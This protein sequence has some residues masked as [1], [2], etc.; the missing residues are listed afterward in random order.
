MKTNQPKKN[1][2]SKFNLNYFILIF[3]LLLV[4]LPA[5]SS[6]DNYGINVHLWNNT[7]LAKVKEANI[8]WIRIDV[9]WADIE[10]RRGHYNFGNVDRVVHYA[11][12]NGLKILAILGDT[13][14]WANGGKSKNFPP[15][16]TKYWTNFISV[17]TKR[18]K[19]KIKYWSIWNEPNVDDFFKGSPRTYVNDILIPAVNT[20]KAIDSN[21]K[22]VAP[23]ITYLTSPGSRWDTYLTPVLNMGKK[24]IDIISMHIYDSKGAQAIMDKIE[25]GDVV[26]DSVMH[27]LNIT[28]CGG[29]D[30][31]LTE[32]G[33][34]TTNITEDQQAEHYLNILKKVLNSSSV[35]K[36]FFYEIKDI[37]DV[38]YYG[39]LKSNNTPKKAYYTYKNFIA[40]ESDYIGDDDNNNNQKKI[41]AYKYIIPFDRET[42]RKGRYIRDEIY[43]TKYNTARDNIKLYYSLSE[44]FYKIINQNPKLKKELRKLLY[45]WT[46]EVF[47][48]FDK[49]VDKDLPDNLIRRTDIFLK[50]LEK[51]SKKQELKQKIKRAITLL[52][53]YEK[54]TINRSLFD[55]IYTLNLKLLINR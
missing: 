15:L 12:N 7:V 39:I 3:I 21:S 17:T 38:S 50:T 29:K 41:C 28:G 51:V 45:L 54:T 6:S 14:S 26:Y 49:G 11:I 48:V 47:N 34:P 55:L 8:G 33:W 27:I 42:I 44:E 13:P 4:G 37:E 32:T 31:W 52:N 5:Y 23:D 19:G 18:Y 10:S 40:N 43:G 20:I 53:I 35:D 24:Y 22:I 16:K 46:D 30:F 2:Q 9:S 1:N 25:K 36:I